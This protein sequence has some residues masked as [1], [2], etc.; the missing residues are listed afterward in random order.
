MNNFANQIETSIVSS[1]RHST[2][3]N[4][5]HAVG[6]V[7]ETRV[8][9]SLDKSFI[10]GALRAGVVSLEDLRAVNPMSERQLA[11]CLLKSL[12]LERE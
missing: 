12:M 6:K 10:T 5:N 9:V 7:E 3:G 8:L 11:A 2:I 4:R 1:K